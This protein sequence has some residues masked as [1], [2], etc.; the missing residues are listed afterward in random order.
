VLCADDPLPGRLA[1]PALEREVVELA[2]HD[3]DEV[4]AWQVQ[5]RRTHR[6]LDLLVVVDERQRLYQPALR[7]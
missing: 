4:A 2:V 7:A 3:A 5:V 6:A 1:E